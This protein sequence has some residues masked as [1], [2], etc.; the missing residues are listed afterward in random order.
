MWSACGRYILTA[1][2]YERL[3]VDNGFNIFR[4]NGTKVLLKSGETFQELHYAEW[5]PHEEGV[6]SRPN[7]EKLR[8]EELKEEGSKPKKF[9]KFGGGSGNGAFQ[10]MMRQNMASNTHDKGP[11]KVDANQYKE[12]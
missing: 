7:I 11:K 4:A 3:K 1:V 6:L 2:L 9:F 12:L 8:R 5:Q 10:Q